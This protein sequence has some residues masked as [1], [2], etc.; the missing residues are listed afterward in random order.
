[1]TILKHILPILGIA[2]FIHAQDAADSNQDF[3]V[4][5]STAPVADETEAPTIVDVAPT[6]T[7]K[8]SKAKAKQQEPQ[9]VYISNELDYVPVSKSVMLLTLHEDDPADAPDPRD[10][11]DTPKKKEVKTSGGL[12]GFGFLADDSAADASGESGNKAKTSFKMGL[13]VGLGYLTAKPD[14]IGYHVFEHSY[15]DLYFYDDADYAIGS[16]FGIIFAVK[17]I[18]DNAFVTTGIY[19]GGSFMS[20]SGEVYRHYYR[21]YYN[22]AT[23]RQTNLSAEVPITVG[24]QIMDMINVEVG[25][26]LSFKVYEIDHVSEEDAYTYWFPDDISAGFTLG[27]SVV[28]GQNHEVG[29][30]VNISSD[31]TSYALNY[32]YWLF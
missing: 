4:E 13:H 26:Q 24:Y 27:A 14:A 8:K 9:Q 12:F 21:H 7:A 19:C 2:T 11:D 22:D 15:S 25:T 3:P 1:M 17:N 6:P 29:F 31:E 20:F 18:I 28:L 23:L 10:G 32:N 16:E 5:E 30:K